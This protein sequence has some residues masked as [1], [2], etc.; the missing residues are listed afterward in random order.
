MRFLFASIVVS[1]LS[2]ALWPWIRQFGL[3]LK[4]KYEKAT[5]FKL[6]EKENDESD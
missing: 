5:N 6:E 3:F 1:L 2:L 4:G